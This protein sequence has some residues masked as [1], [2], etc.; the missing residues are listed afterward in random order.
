MFT[1][2]TEYNNYRINLNCCITKKAVE[3]SNL[4]STGNECAEVKSQELFLLNAY[5]EILCNYKPKIITEECT[6]NYKPSIF[7]RTIVRSEMLSD[8][9]T[10]TLYVNNVNKAQITT[11]GPVYVAV[12]D[13]LDLS[14]FNYNTIADGKDSV[15]YQLIL[16]CSVKNVYANIFKNIDGEPIININIPIVI[17]QEGICDDNLNCKEIIIESQGCISEESYIKII[18]NINSL[19][20][21]CNCNQ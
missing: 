11:S 7:E 15:T 5:N 16:D 20:E 12:N 14:G 19:C 8:N 6:S 21:F 1:S 18:N 3:L 2:L 4:L 10:L 13:L 9:S 17:I